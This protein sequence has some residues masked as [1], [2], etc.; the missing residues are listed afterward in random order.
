MEGSIS[1]H[2]MQLT[3]ETV[4]TFL[5]IVVAVMLI[6]VLYHILFIAVD[7]RKI[8][9]RMNEMTEEVEMLL[10]KPFMI[11]DKLLQMVV[12]YFQAHHEKRAHHEKPHK[13]HHHKE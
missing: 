8:M 5:S 2:F 1:L 7:L 11:A 9:R 6:V 3:P 4:L 13:K 10:M 12:E